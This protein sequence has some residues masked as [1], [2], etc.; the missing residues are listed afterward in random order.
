M[1]RWPGWRHTSRPARSGGGTRQVYGAA[2]VFDPT[3]K[4]ISEKL[5]RATDP[6]H[7]GMISTEPIAVARGSMVVELICGDLAAT[8]SVS[9]DDCASIDCARPTIGTRSP[10]WV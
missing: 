4:R 8:P 10:A 7:Q 9:A 5:T 6:P 3:P 1:R 2:S